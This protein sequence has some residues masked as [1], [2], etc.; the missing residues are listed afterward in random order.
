MKTFLLSVFLLIS[1]SLFSQ[2]LEY[3]W[4]RPTTKGIDNYI[5]TN[6]LVFIADYQ[7]FIGDTLVYEPFISTDDLSDYYNYA[8]GDAGYFEYPDNIIID[9]NPNFID[10]ELS[11]LSKF[12]RNQYR[13]ASMF[14]RG[15]VMHELTHCYIY[16]IMMMAKY[17][18]NLEYVFR[19]GLRMIP[20]D[21]YYADFVT[22]GICEAVVVMMDEMIVSDEQQVL[23]KNDL[24]RKDSYEIKYRYSRQFMMPVIR[25]FGLKPAIYIVLS[26]KPPDDEEILNPQQ[27]YDRLK[28]K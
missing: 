16:Q 15:V 24:V 18:G 28:W 23:I 2:E 13:E 25:E 21:N 7:E 4:G 22:E 27:Y 14:V 11:N 5:E 19:E 12:R 6:W 20:V 9:N 8:Q 17:D 1:I 10:Y 3:K 26:N